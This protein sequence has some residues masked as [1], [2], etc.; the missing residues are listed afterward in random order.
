MNVTDDDRV[1]ALA[2]VV[3]PTGGK[4]ASANIAGQTQMFDTELSGSF[5][6]IDSDEDAEADEE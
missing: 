1:T 2:R 6:S 3:D 4:K 5:E